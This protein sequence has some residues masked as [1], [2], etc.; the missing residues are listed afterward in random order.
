VTPKEIT[1][2]RLRGEKVDRIPNFNILMAFAAKFIGKPMDLFCADYRILVEGNLRCAEAFGI[3]ILST[4]SDAFRE[5]ADFGATIRFPYDSLPVVEH[6]I[7]CPG[8]VKKLKP[9]KPEDSV[10]M[11]DRMRAI[12]LF[13]RKAGDE[14]PILGWIEGCCA[15]AAD[16][17]GLS[18]YIYAFYDEPQMVREIMDI[19]LETAL[20]CVRSQ[21]KAG[22]DII[23]VGDAAASVL[24]PDI[25]REWILPYEQKIFAEIRRC[26]AI[27][28][29]HICGNI[30]ALLSDIKHCGADIVDIDWMV[31]FSKAHEELAGHA[32]VCGNFDPVRIVM[33]GTPKSIAEAVNKCVSSG[34]ADSFIMAGCEIPKMTP[35]E[36]LLAVHEALK[37]L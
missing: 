15:E 9:F 2:A 11:L 18:E 36:N 5:T 1:Q 34:G 37:A 30:T 27:G 22:A 31:D 12:E 16:L 14:Y 6:F 4:M 35:H 23:G 7:A 28:R 19:C 13:K 24:G 17:M 3:D 33:E 32:A 20:H 8:D 29:L 26:G 25:Y 10:R 21:A